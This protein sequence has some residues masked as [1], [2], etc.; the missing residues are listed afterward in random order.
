MAPRKS[1]GSSRRNARRSSSAEEEEEPSQPTQGTQ[2]VRGDLDAK[3]IEDK[4]NVLVRFALFQE[5]KRTPIRRQTIN[6]QVLPAGNNKRA[7]NLVFLRAQEILR[8]KFGCELYELR[9]RNKGEATKISSE[10][11]AATQTQKKKGRPSGRLAAIEEDDDEEDEDEEGGP[12]QRVKKTPGSNQWILRSILPLPIL[13]K[14]SVDE[15]LPYGTQKAGDIEDSGALIRWEKGDGT[16]SGHVG[17]LGIR[18]MI[19]SI[20]MCHNRNVTDDHLHALLR[21]LG[22]YRETVLPYVSSDQHEMPL[23]LDRYL[24]LLARQ[25][26]LEKVKIP[27]PAANP[28]AGSIEWRWGNREAEFSEKAAAKF[29]EDVMFGAEV[30]SDEDDDSDDQRRRRG[31]RQQEPRVN[32]RQKL[33]DDVVKAAGGELVGDL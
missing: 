19:L 7:F 28:E 5:Y 11:P 3:G 26:Y 18:T 13:E 25:S 32:K 27:G 22:L 14:M 23:T 12:T 1:Q 15:P 24:E 4:A 33:R 16:M 17:L 6:E 2:Y 21:R 29:I 8:E 10:T 9:P 20:I 30:D 31:R